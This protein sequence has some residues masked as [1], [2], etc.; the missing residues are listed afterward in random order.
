MNDDRVDEIEDALLTTRQ[1]DVAESITDRDT[2]PDEIDA[3]TPEEIDTPD[4]DLLSE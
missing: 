3:P 4:D 1:L 2:A